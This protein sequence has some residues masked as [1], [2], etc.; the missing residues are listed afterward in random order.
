MKILRVAAVLCVL[1]VFALPARSQDNSTGS[2]VT[3]NDLIGRCQLAVT[4]MDNPDLDVN[5]VD[6]L[7]TGYCLGVVYGVSDTLELNHQACMPYSVTTSQEV[8]VVEKF[9]QD[10]PA[11]LNQS[12]ALLAIEAIHD[13]FPCK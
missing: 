11:K 12:G 2:T 13:A 4:A 3:G 1:S 5:P 8:R 6:A 9:L 7:K 10:H